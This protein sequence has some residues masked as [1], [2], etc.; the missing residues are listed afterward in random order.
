MCHAP[1]EK[2]E[3]LL[4]RSLNAT[5]ISTD[6]IRSRSREPWKSGKKMP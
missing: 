5:K 4:V 2:A 3:Q 1:Q 6:A